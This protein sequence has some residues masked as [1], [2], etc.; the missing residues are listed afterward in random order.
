[1]PQSSLV[2]R[3][4]S[5]QK[6]LQ[7]QEIKRNAATFSDVV[8]KYR[9][10]ETASAYLCRTLRSVRVSFNLAFIAARCHRFLFA[11]SPH[12]LFCSIKFRRLLMASCNHYAP[13]LL[14]LAQCLI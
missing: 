14:P 6:K 9:E 2:R 8:W 5:K 10:E 12:N 4:R 7:K 3:Q 1:M 11:P 13:S